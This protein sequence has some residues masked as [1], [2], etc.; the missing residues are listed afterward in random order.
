ME[1]IKDAVKNLMLTLEGKKT[2]AAQNL[3]SLLKKSLTKR[4]LGHIKINYF[5]RGTLNILVDSSVWLYQLSLKKEAVL[6]DLRKSLKEIK[7]IR[8]RLG[9]IK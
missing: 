8:F 6:I 5:R 4:E 7:E 2:P 3:E 1:P 9:E